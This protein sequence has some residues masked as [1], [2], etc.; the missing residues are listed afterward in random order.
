MYQAN[1]FQGE[2]Y[3]LHQLLTVVPGPTSFEN[4]HTVDGIQHDTF[5]AACHA[6]GIISHHSNWEEC[7]NEAKDMR[8][9]W[10]LCRLLVS[11]LLY[12]GLTDAHRIWDRFADFLCDDLSHHIH[13][14]G[15]P[16]DPS[17]QRPDH[18]FGLYLI[19]IALTAE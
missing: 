9:G 3:Y 1:P 2:I 12:G 19:D 5:E 8:T 15:L 10:Y 17:T 7:F 11:A 13:L 18:D 4:I 6:H 14:C 16:Y